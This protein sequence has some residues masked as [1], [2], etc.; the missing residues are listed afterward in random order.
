MCRARHCATVP[1]ALAAVLLG[2]N[3]LTCRAIGECLNKRVYSKTLAQIKFHA[4]AMSRTVLAREVQLKLN[5][6]KSAT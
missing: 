1:H 2:G 5:S 3:A 4:P 6:E